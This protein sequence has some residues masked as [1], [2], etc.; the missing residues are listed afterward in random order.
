[1][2]PKVVPFLWFNDNLEEAIEFYKVVFGNMNILSVKRSGE[3]GP[4]EKGTVFSATF[5]IEG[6]TFYALN[7]GPRFQFSQAISFFINCDTQEEIDHLWEQLSNGGEPQMCGWVKDKF[8]LSW[9]VV[10]RNL[11]EMLGH[12]DNEKSMA[13]MQAMLS[14]DKLDMHIL[15]AVFNQ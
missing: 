11:G 2:K 1:M 14:M 9:Q 3:D 10:P 7:G 12:F 15:E 6:Q 13:V 4:G 8:G 5:E